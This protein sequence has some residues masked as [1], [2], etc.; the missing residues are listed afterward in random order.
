MTIFCYIF[1]NVGLVRKA[2]Y[3]KEILKAGLVCF[4]V[5][6]T[7]SKYSVLLS[8]TLVSGVEN[9][10][11]A[12]HDDTSFVRRIGRNGNDGWGERKEAA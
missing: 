12:P 5:D 10:K 2:A 3:G 6:R 8:V 9:C 7:F 11:G 1:C 4:G